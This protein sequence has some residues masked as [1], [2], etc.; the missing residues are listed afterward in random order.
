MEHV[1]FLF[2]GQPVTGGALKFHE[3]TKKGNSERSKPS[4]SKLMFVF[5]DKHHQ[6]IWRGKNQKV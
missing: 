3:A 6:K 5:M 1:Y 4:V 2:A